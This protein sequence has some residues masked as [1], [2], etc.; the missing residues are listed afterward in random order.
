MQG[1]TN[2]MVHVL[3]RHSAGETLARLEAAIRAAGLTI[4]ASINQG[5]ETGRASR[6]V[7]FGNPRARA[8]LFEAAP[9][10]A[11]DL[12]FRALVWEDARG[13]VRISYDSPEYLRQRHQAPADLAD[14]L[15]AIVPLVAD[16][17][18]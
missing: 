5:G 12:P 13:R 17:A 7:I 9:T 6:L 16:A 8:R 4:F 14:Q 15:A 2:G 18:S 10:I 1:Q 11:L 3:S